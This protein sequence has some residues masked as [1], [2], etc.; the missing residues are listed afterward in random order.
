MRAR[1]FLTLLVL[2][3]VVLAVGGWAVQAVRATTRPLSRRSQR[4]KETS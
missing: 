4:R 3:V 2:A 1:I